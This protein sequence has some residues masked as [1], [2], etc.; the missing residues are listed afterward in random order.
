MI[1]SE[2]SAFCWRPESKPSVPLPF[3][4]RRLH[5]DWKDDSVTECVIGLGLNNIQF[6]RFGV[7]KFNIRKDKGNGSIFLSSDAIGHKNK[8]LVGIDLNLNANDEY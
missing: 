7:Q 5:G 1:T 2:N 8:L 4:L 3:S 6:R